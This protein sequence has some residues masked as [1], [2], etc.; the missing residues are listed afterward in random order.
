[1]NSILSR[2]IDPLTCPLCHTPYNL[3]TRLP[4]TLSCCWHSV[5]HVCLL[6]KLTVNPAQFEKVK[7][8]PSD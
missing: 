3:S 2:A 7:P 1:M 4:M 6:T 5:C 8:T